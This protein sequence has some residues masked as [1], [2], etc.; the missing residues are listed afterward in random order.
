MHDTCEKIHMH[1]YIG[2]I[3]AYLMLKRK[4]SNYHVQSFQMM[5][6]FSKTIKWKELETENE[7]K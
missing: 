2:E 5:L 6:S 1:A 4:V 3:V 7:E